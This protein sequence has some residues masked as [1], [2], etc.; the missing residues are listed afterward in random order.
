MLDTIGI[1]FVLSILSW[2]LT[3]IQIYRQK[4]IEYQEMN[5]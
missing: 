3:F 1:L 5:K 2:I 4:I